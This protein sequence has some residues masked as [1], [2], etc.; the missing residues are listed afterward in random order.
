MTRASLELQAGESL[1][2]GQN[3][4]VVGRGQRDVVLWRVHVAFRPHASRESVATSGLE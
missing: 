4:D 1:D 3:R 2:L